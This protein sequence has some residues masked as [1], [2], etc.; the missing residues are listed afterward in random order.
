MLPETRQLAF[1]A[2]FCAVNVC[3]ALAFVDLYPFST[4]PMYSDA[5]PTALEL[6]VWTP[7]GERFSLRALGLHSL[8]VHNPHPRFGWDSGPTLNHGVPLARDVLTRHLQAKAREL[9]LDEPYL[10]VVQAAIG[11]L[12]RDGVETVG[13]RERTRW[14]IELRAPR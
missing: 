11:P 12:E 6:E 7:A 2:A 4:M 9:G 14:R 10:E 8:D 13:V 1:A 5:K 3:C